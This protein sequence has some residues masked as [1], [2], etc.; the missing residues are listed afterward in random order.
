MRV[1][2]RLGGWCFVSGSTKNLKLLRRRYWPW[3]KVG[4][5]HPAQQTPAVAL[6]VV[7]VERSARVTTV[8]DACQIER[9]T[10]VIGGS[11][12]RPQ[13]VTPVLAHSGVE[14]R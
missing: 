5:D 1:S 3:S 12:R 6:P 11:L 10:T 9:S 4:S 7:R 13:L 14:L 2:K 8:P